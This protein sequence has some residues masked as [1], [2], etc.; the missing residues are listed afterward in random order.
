M[1]SAASWTS[2][3]IRPIARKSSGD[4]QISVPKDE[5]VPEQDPPRQ[6]DV[7]NPTRDSASS[8]S[9]VASIFA[10]LLVKEGVEQGDKVTFEVEQSHKGPSAI[11][12]IVK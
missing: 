6:G 8:T 12:A 1:S 5:G 7:F 3:P 9:T 2:R 4:I 11:G 10:R